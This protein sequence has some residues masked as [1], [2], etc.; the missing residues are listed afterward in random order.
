MNIDNNPIVDTNIFFY[1]YRYSSLIT[2]IGFLFDN[3][4]MGIIDANK[5]TKIIEIATIKTLI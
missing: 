2:I 5:N 4:I 3:F 1:S